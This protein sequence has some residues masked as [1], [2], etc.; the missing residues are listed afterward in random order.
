MLRGTDWDGFFHNGEDKEDLIALVCSFLRSD[1]ERELV[2]I[3]LIVNC[4][5]DTWRITR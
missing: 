1:D 5:N 4:K 3:P 2:R